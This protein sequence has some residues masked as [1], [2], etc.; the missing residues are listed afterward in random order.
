MTMMYAW[1]STPDGQ[2][3]LPIV[4]FT[5]G[6]DG[7]EPTDDGRWAWR[8]GQAVHEGGWVPFSDFEGWS[9]PSEE[10]GAAYRCVDDMLAVSGPGACTGWYEGTLSA[11]ADWV[12]A[13]R[14]QQRV[15]LLTA[16]VRHPSEYGQ[17]VEAGSAYALLVPL[18]LL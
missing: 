14:T 1:A 8:F 9:R 3:P 11:P 17:A 10:W 5:T 7:F 13:A 2:D 6:Q 18:T 16:P 15:V 4:H 12:A